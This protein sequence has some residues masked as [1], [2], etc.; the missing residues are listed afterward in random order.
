MTRRTSRRRR[1]LELGRSLRVENLETRRLFYAAD[2]NDQIGEVFSR[3]NIADLTGSITGSINPA[4]DVDMYRVEA[5]AGQTLAA[6]VLGVTLHPGLRLFGPLNF[7]SNQTPQELAVGTFV[8]SYTRSLEY[9]VTVSGTYYIGV[10]ETSNEFYSATSGGFDST[11]FDATTG[12]YF[13]VIGD[14][15]PPPTFPDLSGVSFSIDSSA[16]SPGEAVTVTAT[17]ENLENVASGDFEVGIYLSDNDYI[18]TF[19]TLLDTATVSTIPGNTQTTISRTVVIPENVGAGDWHIGMYIDPQG[20]IQE[21]LGS[22]NRN[23]G[24]GV[25]FAEIDI[26]QDVTPPV[27]EGFTPSDNATD[28][29]L[30]ALLGLDFSEPVEKGAGEIGIYRTSDNSLVESVDVSSDS[31]SVNGD[32]VSISLSN[33][34]QGN[35]SYYVLIDQGA[36]VDAASNSYVGLTDSSRW[37]FATTTDVDPRAKAWELDSQHG[38]RIEI[39]RVFGW[40]GQNE[41]WILAEDNSWFF[42]LPSGELYRWGGGTASELLPRSELLHVFPSEYYANTELIINPEPLGGTLEELAYQIDQ[43]L[44]FTLEVTNYFDWGNLEEKWIRSGTGTWYFMTPNGTLYQWGGGNSS[45]LMTFSSVIAEFNTEYYENLDRLINAPNPGPGP[46]FLDPEE[47]DRQYGLDREVT[48]FYDW[49]R[50]SEK[51]IQSVGGTWFFIRPT[52]E[53]YEYRGGD[54]SELLDRSRFIG[55]FE[56]GVYEVTSRLTSASRYTAQP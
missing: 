5:T 45:Q 32:D 8:D 3:G 40:G 39:P 4:T 24:L 27:L 46:E 41:K 7:G 22:N 9:P 42:I 56:T 28:V 36:F 50:L 29:A 43:S 38:F 18:S 6:S 25:D 15:T 20:E 49:G 51:W 55:T 33:P 17:I 10:A 26:F 37:S 52:G 12:D 48:S 31:V 14:V 11:Q 21:T 13:L 1:K 23:Q 35:T 44:N 47:I 2:P 16:A 19:D 34:L 53:F 54:S 30:D